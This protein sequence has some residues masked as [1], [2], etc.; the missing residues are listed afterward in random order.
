MAGAVFRMPHWWRD[1]RCVRYR[2]RIRSP[3]GSGVAHR[4]RSGNVARPYD[5]GEVQ[6]HLAVLPAQR[7]DIAQPDINAVTRHDVGQAHRKNIRPVLVANCYQCHSASSKELKGE[8]RLDTRE[9][10]F[11]VRPGGSAR[12]F[13]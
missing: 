2:V 1:A 4:L 10:A 13:S 12:T 11:S 5:H 6:P 3:S 8:L 7:L 9:G